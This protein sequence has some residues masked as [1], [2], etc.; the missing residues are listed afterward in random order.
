MGFQPFYSDSHTYIGRCIDL[1]YVG[2][3]GMHIPYAHTTDMHRKRKAERQRE[4][5]EE[6]VVSS[7][8]GREE[9]DRW[10]TYRY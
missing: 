8:L 1:L 3:H 9:V 10:F 6:D 2:I 7:G 4:T 5:E